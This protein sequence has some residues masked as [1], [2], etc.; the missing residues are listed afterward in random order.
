MD[1]RFARLGEFCSLVEKKFGRGSI[2]M[3]AKDVCLDVLRIPSGSVVLDYALGGG[4]PRGRVTMFYGKKSSGKS[5]TAL[6]VV[7]NA[8]KVCRNCGRYVET[9]I[10]STVIEQGGEERKVFYA[11]GNCD[12][13]KKGLFF[14]VRY[15]NITV[16]GKIEEEG[17]R[18]YESRLERYE[19]NSY[20][21]MIVGWID[22]EGAYDQEWAKVLGIDNNRIMY[23]RPETAEEAIDV[24]DSW[25]RT[26]A[27][28]LLVIDTLAYLT[29]QIEIEKSSLEW[30]QGIQARLINKFCRK[31]A[32][33]MSICARRWGRAPTM[34]WNNQVRM[35]IGSFGGEVLPGGMGQTFSTSVE[36]KFWP[37]KVEVESI[38]AGNKGEEI[39]VPLYTEV[40]FKVIKNKTAPVGIEGFYRL[41]LRDMETVRKGDISELDQIIR[42]SKYFGIISKEKNQWKYRNNTYNKLL[43][44]EELIRVNKKEERWL[45]NVLLNLLLNKEN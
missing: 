33:A 20:E 11:V 44:I 8:Q 39:Y 34:I 19:K 26:G 45:K 14:P 12:C 18:E 37:G 43:E 7:A 17:I 24:C 22:T 35:K 6:K 15:K 9:E 25:L 5:T 29:P 21:E 10:K 42:W 13:Y 38:K 4:I 40:Q 23:Y 41:I 27:I 30:Q 2:N 32:S 1:S 3:S 28:D 36:V 31:V 16:S